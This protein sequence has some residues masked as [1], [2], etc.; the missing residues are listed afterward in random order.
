MKKPELST[1]T[2]NVGLREVGMGFVCKQE[3]AQMLVVVIN[4]GNA[5]PTYTMHITALCKQG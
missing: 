2:L 3:N 1:S 4:F 5:N